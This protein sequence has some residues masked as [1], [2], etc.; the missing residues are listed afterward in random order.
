MTLKEALQNIEKAHGKGALMKMSDRPVN[1]VETISTGCLPL[2]I[3]LGVGGIPRGR[4]VE[5]FGPESSG[6][7]TL[8]LHVVAEAQRLGGTCVYIDVEHAL[9]PVYAQ[10]I[11]V[12]VDDLYI[13]Q[14][15]YGEQALDIAAE[16]AKSGDVS[17]IVIDSVAALVPRAE[18]EGTS[19]DSHVGLH[20]RLANQAVRVLTPAL[21]RS[22]TACILINQLREKIGGYGNP[23]TTTG[24]RGIRFQA[25]LRMDVRRIETLK[26]GSESYGNR[27]RVKI[28]KNKLAVP[29]RQTEFD[30]LYGVG[31]DKVSAV[32]ETAVN[33]GIVTKSGAWYSFD[34]EQLGQ[35][36]EKVRHYF[37][38]H[39][40]LLARIEHDVRERYFQKN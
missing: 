26:T 38:E 24:G 5:I 17:V 2:D 3:A 16:L 34:G 36:K 10:A 9:D 1:W 23:E 27:T 32:V 7:T 33:D 21:S 29:H 25:S 39:P 40:D 19:G 31:V 14:P 15:D 6:K 37:E 13:S 8:A 22:K 4:L 28:V 12:N 30:I 18:I 20:A 35:G 11:G